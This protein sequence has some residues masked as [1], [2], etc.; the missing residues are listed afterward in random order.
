MCIIVN[1][2]VVFVDPMMQD[3]IN[4]YMTNGHASFEVNLLVRAPLNFCHIF[5]NFT[6]CD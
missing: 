6:Y 1:V 5:D 2:L 3:Q 4:S